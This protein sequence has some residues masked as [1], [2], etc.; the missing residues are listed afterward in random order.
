VVESCSHR[1]ILLK[2]SAC[3][4][5]DAYFP[6]QL[7]GTTVDLGREFSS[8]VQNLTL[9]NKYDD[10]QQ[11]RL[12]FGIKGLRNNAYFHIFDLEISCVAIPFHEALC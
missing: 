9:S 2:A 3:V 8:T 10:E 1:S 7:V 6:S 12:I 11:G 5:S 4:A